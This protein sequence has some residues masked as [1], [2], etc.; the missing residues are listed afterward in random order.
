SYAPFFGRGLIQLT[1]LANYQAYGNYRAF[2]TSHPTTKPAFA[3]LGWDPDTLIATS[4]TVFDAVN[5]A[6]TAGF[7]WLTHSTT[8]NGLTLSDAGIGLT[9]IVSVS[10]YVN[11]N[12]SVQNLNGLDHRLGHFLY[13]KYVLMDLVRPASNTERLTFTWRRNSVKEV[14]L[15]AAG[16]PVPDPATGLPKK[17]FFAGSHT[18]DF[19][20]DHQRP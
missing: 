10:K 20:L 7:Y 19:P 3:A 8:N 12:V 4:Q 1:R 17:R 5:S 18:V 15:D 14:V 9:E 11:G 6:D 2:P 13:L 16:V